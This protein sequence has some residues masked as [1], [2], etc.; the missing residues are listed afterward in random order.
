METITNMAL[1]LLLA[2]TWI[3]IGVGVVVLTKILW[4]GRRGSVQGVI[5]VEGRG[6][7]P[8][9]PHIKLRAFARHQQPVGEYFH[10]HRSGGTGRGHR[11]A[12]R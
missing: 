5:R 11:E 4:T 12:Q 10:H 1:T 6:D 7:K 9:C 2:L 8:F 3:G